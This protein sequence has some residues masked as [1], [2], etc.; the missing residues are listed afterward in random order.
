[1]VATSNGEYTP[2]AEIMATAN[3]VSKLI[4]FDLLTSCTNVFR[5]ILISAMRGTATG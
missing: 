4:Y 3:K 5:S 2:V 1:M